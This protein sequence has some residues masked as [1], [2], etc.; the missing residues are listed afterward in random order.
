ML[1]PIPFQTHHSISGNSI[2]GANPLVTVVVPTYKRFALVQQA[3]ASV[4]AQTYKN[5]EII[6][7]DDGS[8]DG[9]AEA[10]H[11]M[12]D[13]RI[14]ILEM[15]HIGNIAVLRN[16][17]V[18][19]GSGEWVA[20]LDS[21]DEW[22]PQKLEMQLNILLR[23]GKRWGYGGFELM[24]KEKHT[25]PNKAGIYHPISGWIV[26][27]LLTTE[28]SVNIGTLLLERTLFEEAGGFNSDAAL[29][30]REDYELVLRLALRAET[31][32]LP[33]LLVRVREHGGRSTN[34]FDYG[35]DRTA[36]MY[37]YF[38]RS[39]PDKE[40]VKIAR[41]RMAG[42]LTDSAI[43]RIRNKNYLEAAGRLGKALINGDNLRHM[44]SAVRRGFT[45]SAPADTKSS[46][47]SK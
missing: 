11:S 39:R 21:D 44:L 42:E 37:E 43:Q 32:A 33:E 12:N 9:T 30:Y 17:G 40:L 20:F 6:I 36:S 41:R 24:N 2:S 1:N 38:I 7:V 25:I 47:V 45:M 14:K 23:E 15:Q 18:R 31:L 16:A 46:S 10:I 28:A 8:D 4:M 19:A 3:I 26:K 35:H 27:E 5:W 29:L 34:T 13:S 22:V